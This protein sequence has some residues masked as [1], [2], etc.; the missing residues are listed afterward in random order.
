MMRRIVVGLGIAVLTALAACGESTGGSSGGPAAGTAGVN[1]GTPTLTIK[2]GD[3]NVFSPTNPTVHVG[4][5]IQWT[6]PGTTNHTVTFDTQQALSDVSLVPGGTWEVKFSTPG[7]YAYLC[8]IHPGM[9]G[10][11]VVS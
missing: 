1:L 5:I 9:T 2:A 6:V 10:T 8:A 11:I 7:T 4:D 3:D